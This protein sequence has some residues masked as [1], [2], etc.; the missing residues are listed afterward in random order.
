MQTVLLLSGWGSGLIVGFLGG[1]VL[2]TVL[3]LRGRGRAGFEDR[4]AVATCLDAGARGGLVSGMIAS[5]VA[6]FHPPALP[7]LSL[8]LIA[9]LPFPMLWVG[10]TARYYRPEY[11][12]PP[13]PNRFV[14]RL[15]RRVARFLEPLIGTRFAPYVEGAVDTALIILIVLIALAAGDLLSAMEEWMVW[16]KAGF[17]PR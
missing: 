7:S 13:Q 16:G 8:L 10:L 6:H 3:G 9:H 2:L 5:L 1:F 17:P 12:E 4:R 14:P 11:E 15:S